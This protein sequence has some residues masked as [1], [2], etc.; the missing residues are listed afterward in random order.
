MLD[1]IRNTLP[2]GLVTLEVGDVSWTQRVAYPTAQRNTHITPQQP[3][4][5]I[6]T[7]FRAKHVSVFSQLMPY[8][9]DMYSLYPLDMKRAAEMHLVEHIKNFVGCSPGLDLVGAR[10]SREILQFIADHRR[11]H[12]PISFYILISF[13]LNACVHVDGEKTPFVF[14]GVT[15]AR[16]IHVSKK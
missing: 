11:K 16:V 13:L 7:T 10:A 15:T 6:T 8:F 1:V 14:E 4:V 2:S 5:T 3:A 12:V 9:D